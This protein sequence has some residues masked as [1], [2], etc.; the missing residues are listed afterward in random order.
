MSGM[1]WQNP[2]SS[3]PAPYRAAGVIEAEVIDRPPDPGFRLVEQR[4][5]L[6]DTYEVERFLP[7]IL[8]RALARSWID[9]QFRTRFAR[10]PK[11]TLAAF[12]V[13]LPETISIDYETREASRPRIVV[14]EKPRYGL[15][16]KRLLYLQLIM[17]AGK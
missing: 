3:V 1:N 4:T 8:G 13:L 16:R 17:M 15:T 2:R 7:D 9:P 10:D 11:G 6:Q 14:Y 5:R 12:D